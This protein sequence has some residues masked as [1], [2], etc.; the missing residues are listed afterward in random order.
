MYWRLCKVDINL[1]AAREKERKMEIDA[2]FEEQ[3]AILKSLY[4]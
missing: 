4:R 1:L 2:I 3:L